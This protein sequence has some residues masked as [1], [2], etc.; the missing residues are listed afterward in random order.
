[1]HRQPNIIYSHSGLHGDII[2]SLATV[3]RIGAGR[4][5][6]TFPLAYHNN[7]RPL[8]EAQPYI[9]ECLP[10]TS[11]AV[12]THNLD[13]FRCTNG[14]GQVPLILN[15]F[16]AFNIREEGWADPWLELPPHEP[17]IKGKYALVN[18][19]P[20]YPAA[21]WDWVPYIEKLKKE[22]KRVYYVGYECDHVGP[23]AELEYF[24]TDNAL[25]FAQ[26]IKGAQTLV[27]NQSMGLAIA[28]GLGTPYRLMVADNHT[29]C[30]H[31][32][33]NETILNP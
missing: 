21:A 17:L 32:T 24:R 19:T 15:H 27:A 28:Q 11:P 22:F 16:R 5:K 10:E 31:N 4:Y 8:L 33:P 14:L 9:L 26:V 29:N 23:F 30:I 2:Y 18:V 25:E 6:T 3:K 7:I 1:M 13:A 12:V 20:R